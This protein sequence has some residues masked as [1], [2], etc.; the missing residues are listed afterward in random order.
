MNELF[1]KLSDAVLDMDEDLAA[2]TAQNIIEQ[3]LDPAE[4][5]KTALADGMERAGILYEK[6]EYFIPELLGSADAMY[7]ALDILKRHIPKGGFEKKYRVVI[8]SIEGDTHDIGKNIVSL[9]LDGAEF[10]VLDLGRDVK[11]KVFVQNAIDFGADIIAVSALMTTV[12]GRI[13]G[14]P[15]LLEEMGLRDRF[16]VIVGGRPLSAEFAEKIGADGYAPNAA[17]A[18]RMVR[19]LM[20]L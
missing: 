7:R 1:K 13:A 20:K 19:E 17:A 15:A 9:I 4:A 12:M 6:E 8:G 5:I 16:K 14:V 11:P 2:E 10:E 3:G 18:L